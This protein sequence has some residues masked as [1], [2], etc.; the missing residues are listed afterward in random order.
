[1]GGKMGGNAYNPLG[2]HNIHNGQNGGLKFTLRGMFQANID[3]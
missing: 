2:S 1:M 3:H